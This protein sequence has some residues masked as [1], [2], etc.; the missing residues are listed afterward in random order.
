[1]AGKSK[2]HG[3]SGAKVKDPGGVTTRK[4]KSKRGKKSS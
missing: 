2:G 1:M 4:I 3:G